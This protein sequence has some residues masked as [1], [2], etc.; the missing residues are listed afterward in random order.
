MAVCGPAVRQRHRAGAIV[1]LIPIKGAKRT[2]V[3]LSLAL[4]GCRGPLPAA[5]PTPETISLRLLADDATVPLLRE[6]VSQ[7]HPRE[8]IAWDIRVGEPSTILSWLAEARSSFAMLGYLPDSLRND[9]F[10]Q[11]ALWVTPVGQLGVVFVVHLDNPIANLTG[12][13]L[14]AILQ[15]RVTNW[16]Q[17]GGPS[18]P[19]TLIAQDESSTDARVVQAIVL[20][21]RR[22]SRAARLATTGQTV[23]DLVKATPGGIGYVSMGYLVPEVR[24]VPVEGISP[25][26]G[27]VTA[28]RYMIRTPIVFAGLSE[29]GDDAYRAFFAWIQS[30]EGQAVV[31]RR[32]GGLP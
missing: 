1:Q 18:L 7:Y 27:E 23:I 11:G 12:E 6:L 9:N 24:A 4:A 20:G 5:S 16:A 25:T 14:R 21:Q 30:P 8:L 3:I 19:L 10:S 31:R 32:Y 29:P 26:P 28:E 2:I 13:Q 22:F 17:I 15:G